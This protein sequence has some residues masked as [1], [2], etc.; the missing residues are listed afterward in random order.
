MQFG[1]NDVSPIND[2]TRARGTMRGAGDESTAIENQMTGEREEV[3]TYGWYLRRMIEDARKKGVSVV[4][5]SPVPRNA[6]KDSAVTRNVDYRTWADAAAKTSGAVF[7]DLN[8]LVAVRYDRLGQSAVAAFFP[9]DD[10]H[11]SRAGAELTAGA[12][13]AGLEALP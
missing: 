11:T 8:E 3:H 2:P 9:T 12:A 1:H 13:A 10:T 5:C 4:V 7:M 6:W